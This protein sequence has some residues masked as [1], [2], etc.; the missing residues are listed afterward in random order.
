MFGVLFS[1]HGD[2][3]LTKWNLNKCM[4]TEEFFFF[5]NVCEAMLHEHFLTKLEW[6]PAIDWIDV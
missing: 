6:V 3:F 4:L 2:N 5:N 1:Y